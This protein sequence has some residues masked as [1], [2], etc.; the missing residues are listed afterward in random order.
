M[1]SNIAELLRELARQAMAAPV[2]RP[3][4][5]SRDDWRKTHLFKTIKG[6]ATLQLLPSESYFL[7]RPEWS[8]FE[9][10][11]TRL[12]TDTKTLA[13]RLETLKHDNFLVKN[14]RGEVIATTEDLTQSM[15]LNIDRP[16]TDIVL[17]NKGVYFG[18]GITVENLRTGT[19]SKD[20]YIPLPADRREYQLDIS[21]H[22]AGLALH[23][24]HSDPGTSLAVHIVS[25]GPARVEF[26]EKAAGVTVQLKQSKPAELAEL[27]HQVLLHSSLGKH[28]RVED[29]TTQGHLRTVTF[30]GP[31]SGN[32]ARLAVLTPRLRAADDSK[33]HSV[34]F[35][36]RDQVRFSTTTTENKASF[37]IGTTPR[38][39]EKDFA[40]ELEQNADRVR[41]E[42]DKLREDY[43]AKDAKIAP[44][45]RVVPPD[46]KEA[47]K[48][49]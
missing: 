29:S 35:I 26:A 10:D 13:A 2:P 5:S 3:E 12:K 46:R 19:I 37:S 49:R 20:G 9:A 27:H 39:S 41:Q 21:G 38:S 25:D 36:A 43:R 6:D 15:R 47:G 44:M 18:D 24:A 22:S 17:D 48:P 11:G 16:N 40:R 34:D 23:V 14:A 7:A 30:E 42:A 1:S 4:M 28:V 33:T 31:A 45:P 32:P 8:P